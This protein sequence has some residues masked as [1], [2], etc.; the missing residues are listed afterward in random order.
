MSTKSLFKAFL[1]EKLVITYLWLFCLLPGFLIFIA[2]IRL[3]GL[4]LGA[5]FKLKSLRFSIGTQGPSGMSDEAIIVLAVIGY[6][7]FLNLSRY[8]AA[9]YTVR[10]S[11]SVSTP[12]PLTSHALE[13][14]ST[15][16]LVMF[17]AF[18]SD[19]KL[20]PAFRP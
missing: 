19:P 4:W 6:L 5:A 3:F 14:I 2:A 15:I 13:I 18:T 8:L 9:L 17:G 11:G 10:S 12:P 16:V 7:M 1:L 20:A